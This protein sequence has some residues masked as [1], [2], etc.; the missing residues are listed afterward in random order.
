MIYVI[1]HEQNWEVSPVKIGFTE[2]QSAQER[3]R[4]VQTGN[5]AKLAVLHEMEGS[6]RDE[7]EIHD[8][9]S[10]YRL[11]GEWFDA[12]QM[13]HE[14]KAALTLFSSA[15]AVASAIKLAALGLLRPSL[16]MVNDSKTSDVM[17]NVLHLESVVS[18]GIVEDAVAKCRALETILN[19]QQKSLDCLC[20]E[21]RNAYP[22]W[23]WAK[24]ANAEVVDML[25]EYYS[26]IFYSAGFSRQKNKLIHYITNA[27]KSDS[28][29]KDAVAELL[30]KS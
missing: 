21:L 2:S 4:G 22:G 11:N 5:P 17:A 15:N 3:L 27:I 1:G 19:A 29:I 10:A 7:K 16:E 9:L 12:S 30:K 23:E 6:F 14:I 28:E 20:Q 25:T 26:M 13:P 24:N 8:L 18:C